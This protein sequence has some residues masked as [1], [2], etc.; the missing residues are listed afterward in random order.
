MA[1]FNIFCNAH[2]DPAALA[3]LQRGIAS[4]HLLL[5]EKATGNLAA[6]SADPL[7][8]DADI[9]LGQPDPAQ[10][11]VCQRLRWIHLT[12]AGFTRYDNAPFRQALAARN[13]TLTNSSGVFDEP[14]AEHLLAFMLADA[15]QLPASFSNQLT[16]RGWPITAIRHRSRLLA[17]QTVLIVGLGAIGVRLAEF[18]QPLR[19]NL[20]GVRR[21]V[22]GDEPIRTVSV[23][24]IEEH[25]P[26]ADHVIDILPASDDSNAFFS[27]ARLALIKTGAI[28]YNIGRGTTVDQTALQAALHANRLRAAYLDVT[29][30]EPL[31]A[32][33]PLWK[34]PNC[35]ITP[36][37]GGGHADEHARVVQHFLTNL[38]RYE[39]GKPLLDRVV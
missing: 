20:V 19:M 9:A 37:T 8:N 7:L 17:G 34:A 30:P 38:R 33:H 6:G 31:P 21:R 12:S 13:A 28:F 10:A 3:T 4:H 29:D 32:D 1:T 27:A 15:R 18:L 23:S 35:W 2:F 11:M 16:A 24:Q 14:C 5:S 22:R 39:T 36:H 26:T 25:L